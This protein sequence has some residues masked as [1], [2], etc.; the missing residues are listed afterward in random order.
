M[1]VPRSEKQRANNTNGVTNVSPNSV[2][3]ATPTVSS[4]T[5]PTF[6]PPDDEDDHD[7]GSVKRS[8]RKKDQ[9]CYR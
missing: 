4:A 9:V 8:K 5:T 6:L 7:M 1:R 2:N 3:T